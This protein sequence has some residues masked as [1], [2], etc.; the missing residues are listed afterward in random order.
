M[1]VKAVRIGSEKGL[2]KIVERI[3]VEVD[4]KI[5]HNGYKRG[6]NDTVFR[7]EAYEAVLNNEI[8]LSEMCN[9]K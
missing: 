5:H 6:M 1:S 8:I 9:E 2:V 7:Y 3:E 4:G